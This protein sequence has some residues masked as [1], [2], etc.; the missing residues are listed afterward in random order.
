MDW[1][2]GSAPPR[3]LLE[4]R[5]CPIACTDRVGRAARRGG[6]PALGPGELRGDGVALL[7]GAGELVHQLLDA[8]LELAVAGVELVGLRLL[9]LGRR[10]RLLRLLRCLLDGL[11]RRGDLP[12]TSFLGLA[13]GG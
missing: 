8:V 12:A 11:L 10:G 5:P 6:L 2:P 1:P 3:Q 9:A 7:A 4:P 13:P